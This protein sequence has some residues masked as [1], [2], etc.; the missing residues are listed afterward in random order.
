MKL[1][2]ILFILI[3]IALLVSGCGVR[4]MQ[5]KA[6][7]VVD[8]LKETEDEQIPEEDSDL[9]VPE[10]TDAPSDQVDVT[11]DPVDPVEDPAPKKTVNLDGLDL[12]LGESVDEDIPEDDIED[13]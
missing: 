13:N 4:K 6:V 2:S 12:G 7:P 9:N 11:P 8:E 1:V 3:A 10:M 5:K